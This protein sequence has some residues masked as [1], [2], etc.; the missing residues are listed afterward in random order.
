[1]GNKAEGYFIT[2]KQVLGAL[3][4]QPALCVDID[5]KPSDFEDSAH[6]KIFESI[7]SQ[8]VDGAEKITYSS[9]YEF[10]NQHY[11]TGCVKASYIS[12]LADDL[13]SVDIQ[14]DAALLKDLSRKNK[15]LSFLDKLRKT[16]WGKANDIIDAL[17]K[18][19]L[20]HT[21]TLAKNSDI[22]S[23]ASRLQDQINSYKARGFVGYRTGFNFLDT[24][25]EG[26]IPQ[27][28]WVVGGYTSVGKTSFMMQLIANVL[29]IH[30][31][32]KVAVFSTEMGDGSNLLRLISNKTG[33]S[34][35]GILRGQ[36]H[37]EEV[38]KKIDEAFLYFSSK[39]V[40][41]HDDINTFERIYLR[42]KQLKMQHGLNI[43]FVD[44]IQNMNPAGFGDTIYSK[45]SLIPIQLQD[46]AKQLDIT[47]IAL[48]QVS[49]ESAKEKT[50]VIGYKGAGEIAAAC[51]LGLW[52]KRHESNDQELTCYIR[53]NRHGPTGKKMLHYNNQFTRILEM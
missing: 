50:S 23:V 44:F 10:I 28:F 8:F 7:I 45:M 34:S 53:K 43:V 41:I 26:Y 37:I 30:S 29:S 13:V 2:E 48:S 33:I 49:N 6:Q 22:K 36:H 17:N 19:L 5:L 1:V 39:D 51:D 47:V 20:Q 24:A 15:L 3:I 12:S 11:G 9:I 46:M 21:I 38:R 16:S 4:V 52:L 14:Q 18:G 25:I 42:C 27:H 35:L 40:W 31:D 32:I